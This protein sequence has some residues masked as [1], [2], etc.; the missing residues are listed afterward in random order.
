MYFTRWSLLVG[1]AGVMQGLERIASL[2]G[3]C[4]G[5]RSYDIEGWIREEYPDRRYESCHSRNSYEYVQLYEEMS[6]E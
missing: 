5:F 6:E 2:D 1:W 3:C 4:C